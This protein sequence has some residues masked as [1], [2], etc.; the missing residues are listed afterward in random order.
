MRLFI[1]AT[2]ILAALVHLLPLAGVLGSAQLN[3]LYGIPIAEP[4]LELLMR[5]RAVLFGLLGGLLLLAAFRPTLQPAAFIA[6]LVSVGSFL[7][8][9]LLVGEINPLLR[10][11]VIVDAVAL[12]LLLAGAA[13]RWQVNAQLAK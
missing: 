1:S 9:A 2:L 12:V 11:V 13:A 6:G 10:R 3:T 5:H 4:N 8:L 7:L